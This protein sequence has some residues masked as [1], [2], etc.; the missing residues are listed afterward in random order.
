MP[1]YGR[2][3]YS[4]LYFPWYRTGSVIF[5]ILIWIAIIYVLIEL[6]LLA[7]VYVLALI[8][9]LLIREILRRPVRRRIWW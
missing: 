6:F 5:E 2:G 7:W 9:L 8:V 1:G 4:R 3:R